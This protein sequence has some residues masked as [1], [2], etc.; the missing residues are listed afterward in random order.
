MSPTRN[1]AKGDPSP[2]DCPILRN[3]GPLLGRLNELLPFLYI[4]QY[5]TTACHRRAR[6][7]S[8]AQGLFAVGDATGSG[9]A[10]RLGLILP[11]RLCR[12]DAA[13]MA[14]TDVSAQLD[15][16][17]EA[18]LA[19]RRREVQASLTRGFGDNLRLADRDGLDGF[20]ALRPS[21]EFFRQLCDSFDYVTEVEDNPA[22]TVRVTGSCRFGW[23][24][25]GE[26][27]EWYHAAGLHDPFGHWSPLV[28]FLV[29]GKTTSP[30]GPGTQ[31]WRQSRLWRPGEQPS[32]WF[33]IR[34]EVRDA[35]LGVWL[36]M[37]KFGWALLHL[38]LDDAVLTIALSYVYD[39]FETLLAWSREVAEGDLPV[40]M[41]INE[42]G[43]TAV[44]TVL[45]LDDAQRV[46]LRVMNKDEKEIMLEG[47][48]SR[49]ALGAALR[50]ELR[51]FFVSEFDPE[52]W[53]DEDRWNDP[54][55]LDDDQEAELEDAPE[56]SV[57]VRERVLNHPWIA[58]GD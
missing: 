11:L 26:L 33:A 41:E 35:R 38:S 52:H 16:P 48:V 8:A 3:N 20:C 56:S 49:S 6:W 25:Y 57:G 40:A 5:G 44:L 31:H 18:T 36:E 9:V 7:S 15:N 32:R 2:R 43:S 46:L 24:S 37:D 1:K 19:E 51:R 17:R 30:A 29:S 10:A 39:P 58:D 22:G 4:A 55:A 13:A 27:M 42:E 23:R 50:A 14:L 12:N 54:D 21:A 45:P 28:P 47:I 34:P 53:D